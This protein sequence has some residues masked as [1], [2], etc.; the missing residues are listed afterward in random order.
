MEHEYDDKKNSLKKNHDQQK[1]SIETDYK[2][3]RNMEIQ[4]CE[5]I[6]K[7]ITREAME[8]EQ[9]KELFLKNQQRIFNDKK[10]NFQSRIRSEQGEKNTA[11]DEKEKIKKDFEFQREDLEELTEKQIEDLKERYEVEK[12]RIEDQMKKSEY[13]SQAKHRELE[14]EK[15]KII[16]TKN[17]K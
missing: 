3:K 15:N 4:R 2:N 14:A 13:E 7:E 16:E 9:F 5:E 6:R 8:F 12:K 11:L 1:K 17:R 10:N